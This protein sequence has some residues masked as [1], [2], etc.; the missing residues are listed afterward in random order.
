MKD[1]ASVSKPTMGQDPA[2]TRWI[3]QE[4]LC[5]ES[6]CH[7]PACPVETVDATFRDTH[8]PTGILVEPAILLPGLWGEAWRSDGGAAPT[9]G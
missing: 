5:I 9:V 2:L 1:K 7:N 3:E 4:E 8:R 6:Y